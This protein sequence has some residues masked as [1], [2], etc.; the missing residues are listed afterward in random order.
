[1]EPGA[2][3]ASG[4]TVTAAFGFL[5]E[6]R[7][8]WLSEDWQPG[9]EEKAPIPRRGWKRRR[10]GQPVPGWEDCSGLIKHHRTRVAKSAKEAA[11]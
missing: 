1:V 9:Q 4:R 3:E 5:V 6:R 10:L 7:S 8:L 11:H 2:L